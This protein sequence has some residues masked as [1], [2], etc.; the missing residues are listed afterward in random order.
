MPFHVKKIKYF[1]PLLKGTISG[2]R[3]QAM[4][5]LIGH[6]TGGPKFGCLNPGNASTGT[7]FLKVLKISILASF[8][9]PL[10]GESHHPLAI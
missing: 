9:L 10:L 6:L 8:L 1:P 4:A 3:N 7:K 2:G 5:Q